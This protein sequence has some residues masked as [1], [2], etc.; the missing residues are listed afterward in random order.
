MSNQKES[1]CQ[2]Q[3]T[4][5]GRHLSGRKIYALAK[6]KLLPPEEQAEIAEF[7]AKSSLRRTTAWLEKGGI[8]VCHRT[9]GDFLQWYRLQELFRQDAD[10][11]KALVEEMQQ[12]DPSLTPEQIQRAG[13]LF[14]TRRAIK[15]EDPQLWI[16]TQELR[17]KDEKLELA[18]EK[19]REQLRLEK[20]G[21]GT[22]GIEPETL[23]QI[24]KEIK[25]M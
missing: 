17:M 15:L 12:M 2:R 13:Q 5:A 9:V 23:E 25:L 18:R 4:N 16:L 19:Q 24:E 20:S 22:G 6:L 8:S 14:F 1:G 21:K 3:Q 10:V 7:G 11:V